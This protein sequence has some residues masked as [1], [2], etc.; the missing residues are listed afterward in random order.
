MKSLAIA[1][2]LALSS[3]LSYGSERLQT[4]VVETA[5]AAGNF[6]TLVELVVAANLD[7]GLK[8]PGPLT[9]FAPIDAAFNELP[10]GAIQFFFSNLPRL[11]RVLTYHVARG[12]IDIPGFV[13]KNLIT[14]QGQRVKISKIA[15]DFFVNDSKILDI[16]KVKN[17]QIVVIDSVLRPF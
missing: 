8:T 17:G 9:V 15:S 16:I 12:E 5:K 2:V 3:H 14:R 7:E 1:F 6:K 4:D 10:E 13:G 11:G